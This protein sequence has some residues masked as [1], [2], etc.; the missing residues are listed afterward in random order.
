[1]EP[2]YFS[3]DEVLEALKQRYAVHLEQTTLADY[4]RDLFEHIHQAEQR[5]GIAYLKEKFGALPEDYVVTLFKDTVFSRDVLTG[6]G[7]D[8]L[9][10]QIAQDAIAVFQ[11]GGI[12]TQDIFA[13]RDLTGEKIF[14]PNN[15]LTDSGIEVYQAALRGEKKFLLPSEDIPP[16]QAQIDKVN[17]LR[18]QLKEKGYTEITMRELELLRKQTDCS[19]KTMRSRMGLYVLPIN[20]NYKRYYVLVEEDQDPMKGVLWYYIAKS[21]SR[22]NPS[23]EVPK[24]QIIQKQS[25]MRLKICDPID[26]EIS[27]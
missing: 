14:L 10:K 26:G 19:E 17:N 7:Y 25:W 18:Q 1:L 8:V 3:D 12:S 13:L 6:K 9:Q 20:K 15:T 23:I 2:I 11:K 27:Y 24:N 5:A 22:K 21:R 16:T 4:E